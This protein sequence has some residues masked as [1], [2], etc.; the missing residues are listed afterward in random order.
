MDGTGK[1]YAALK[2]VFT[3]AEIKRLGW[4]GVKTLSEIEGKLKDISKLISNPTPTP[5]PTPTP[6]ARFRVY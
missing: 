4:E 2:T 5:T 6:D 1:D 3:E